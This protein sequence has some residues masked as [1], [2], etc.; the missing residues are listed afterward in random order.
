MRV[1][2][3]DQQPLVHYVGGKPI[4]T[5]TPMVVLMNEGSASASEILAG[6]LGDHG[7]ATLIGKQ[8][9]GK[10]TVQEI[11]ELPGG[12]SIRVTVARWLTPSGHDIAEAGIPPD[13]EVD[14]TL[15]DYEADE[16]PQL[17]QAIEELLK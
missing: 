4:D 10:G 1:V 12:S 5:E 8:T 2:R 16:D 14:R 3:R 7:R 15:E 11:F 6:A 13:I 9:F 17:E